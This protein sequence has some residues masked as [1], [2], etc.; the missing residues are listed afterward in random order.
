MCVPSHQPCHSRAAGI[1][2]QNRSADA[3][4]VQHP[5]GPLWRLSRDS[6]ARFITPL[7]RFGDNTEYKLL[8]AKLPKPH[9]ERE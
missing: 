6:K 4:A 7:Q 2:P 5:L 8:Q 3:Q 1:F 9:S